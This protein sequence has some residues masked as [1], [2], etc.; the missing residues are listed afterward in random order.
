MTAS[1]N[2][3][4]NLLRTR[5][6]QNLMQRVS[7]QPLPEAVTELSALFGEL[8]DTV[9]QRSKLWDDAPVFDAKLQLRE[10]SPAS[11]QS[12]SAGVLA[13]KPLS[14]WNAVLPWETSLGLSYVSLEKASERL[15]A[16][17]KTE[18]SSAEEAKSSSSSSPLPVPGMLF[19]SA[20]ITDVLSA[21][22]QKELVHRIGRS[23][24]NSDG[25]DRGSDRGAFVKA[26]AG[27][28][29][30][31]WSGGIVEP[32]DVLF[33]D[34][35]RP[36]PVEAVARNR[37]MG[38]LAK[39]LAPAA[40]TAA[41]SPTS[42]GNYFWSAASE[43]GRLDPFPRSEGSGGGASAFASS[44]LSKMGHH[45]KSRP[46]LHDVALPRSRAFAPFFVLELPDGACADFVA[47]TKR[48]SSAAQSLALV[49]ELSRPLCLDIDRKQLVLAH[50]CPALDA[51][52][53]MVLRR[54]CSDVLQP[55]AHHVAAGRRNNNSGG[56]D[57]GEEAPPSSPATGE[58]ELSQD[59]V[60]FMRLCTRLSLGEPRLL[61][62]AWELLADRLRELQ[63][64]RQDYRPIVSPSRPPEDLAAICDVI[65][66]VCADTSVWVP[67]SLHGVAR[68][69]L[70]LK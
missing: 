43:V 60:A 31:F 36:L 20:G 49:V 45:Q 16:L 70:P 18:S 53:S 24:R 51:A 37:D 7:A 1:V 10:L 63:E 57:D 58:H 44:F 15:A 14:L 30:S 54:L 55:G 27:D 5:L 52:A 69:N 25:T 64:Q 62:A 22:H 4:L 47:E 35:A 56:A 32:I 40:E 67:D 34:G 8:A 68:R 23:G 17:R 33:L 46:L 28:P 21:K 2:S 66:S 11:G 42:K 29:L 13:E 50:F 9:P 39:A 26:S 12:V 6:P 59:D 3:V 19:A 65:S 41:T 48:Q 38:L 61:M